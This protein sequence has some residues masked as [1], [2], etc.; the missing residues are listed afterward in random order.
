M[1]NW[2]DLIERYGVRKQLTFVDATTGFA[3]KWRP[4]NERRNSIPMTRHYPDRSSAFDSLKICFSRSK[5][6]YPV[7]GR[8]KHHQYGISGLLPLTSFRQVISGSDLKCRLFSLADWNTTA[9][10]GVDRKELTFCR[11]EKHYTRKAHRSYLP[12]KKM[13]REDCRLN[14]LQQRHCFP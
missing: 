8:G 4:R 12:S 9:E 14:I 5:T 2:Q 6:L 11:R 10:H 3:G 13:F 7:L 1:S